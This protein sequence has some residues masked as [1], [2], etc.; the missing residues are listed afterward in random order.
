MFKRVN[1]LNFFKRNKKGFFRSGGEIRNSL[2][3]LPYSK[4]II[5]STINPICDGL[6]NTE[7]ILKKG[8]RREFAR[9]KHMFD[10]QGAEIYA[11][12]YNDG[13]VYFSDD[14][15]RLTVS[16]KETRYSLVSHNY[17]VHEESTAQLLK[18]HFKMIN[19]I[20]NA[21]NTV[22]KRLGHLTLLT[23]KYDASVPVDLTENVV[24]EREREF[25][26]DYGFLSEQTS[27]KIL[28]HPYDITNISLAGVNFRFEEKL[29][30][31][32]KIVAQTSSV[33]YEILAA[34]IVGNPNQ[35]GVYQEQAEIRLHNTIE[36]VVKQFVALAEKIYG[37]EIDFNVLTKP[38]KNRLDE[39]KA[40]KEIAET[41]KMLI[42]QGVITQEQA[43]K[44]F[45][46]ETGY[47]TN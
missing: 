9:F 4:A 12:L 17:Q 5:A 7:L 21:S 15:F 8:E 35:T 34:A 26:E 20:L 31:E 43:T 22:V 42:E 46:D 11:K 18:P 25:N 27:L 3:D 36:A 16:D 44:I 13:I 1:I 10:T 6:R 19:D 32:I 40:N 23:P 37:L 33:P 39:W 14:D 2:P 29:Q 38:Q 30:A 45:K 41:L 24:K 28:K 47:G